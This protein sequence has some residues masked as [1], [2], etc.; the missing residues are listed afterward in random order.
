[1]HFFGVWVGPQAAL[2]RYL[3]VAADLHAGRRPREETI[4]T[5]GPAV[6]QVCNQYLPH[7][8]PRA[9]SGGIFTRWFGS[10]RAVVEHLARCMGPGGRL[11]DVGPADFLGYRQKTQ[12][13]GLRAQRG[14]PFAA[15]GWTIIQ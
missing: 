7:Q 8:F 4:A 12:R 5:E 15:R 11:A 1:M 2:Q 10:C 9:D 14:L 3:R 6:K 13:Q